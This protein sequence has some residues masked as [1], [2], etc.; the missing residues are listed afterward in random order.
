MKKLETISFVCVLYKHSEEMIQRM[1]DSIDNVLQYCPFFDYEIVL[2]ENGIEDDKCLVYE[3]MSNS[4]K[5]CA[6]DQ[7]L[8]YCGGNNKAINVAKGDYIIVTNPDIIFTDSLC[9]DWL[10]GTSKMHNCISGRLIGTEKWYTY[11]SSFPTDKKYD[12][13]ELP[14]FYDQPTLTK[15]GNWKS[16]KYVDGCLFCIPKNVW[17]EIGGFDEDLFPGYFG[18]NSLCFQAFL[19]GFQI[20]DC[21]IEKLFKHS[22]GVR[23]PMEMQQIKDWSKAARE[24]FYEKYALSN[25]DKFLEYL[26][27]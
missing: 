10:V 24:K 1:I 25:W 7:N 2:W 18:E 6:I 8:G 11:A 27:L 9:I 16:F 3:G 12:P 17:E 23:S 4:V 14:F 21:N 26:R 13:K 20:K 22:G 19:K 15:P 5:A